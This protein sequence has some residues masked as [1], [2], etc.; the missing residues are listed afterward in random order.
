M[1]KDRLLKCTFSGIL[2]LTLVA[3]GAQTS[4]QGDASSASASSQKEELEQVD[5]SA[6][7]VSTENQQPS[8]TETTETTRTD[9]AAEPQQNTEEATDDGEP[10]PMEYPKS[11]E[12]SGDACMG[13]VV[14][15][16]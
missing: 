16:Y 14:L 3:C 13:D 10:A 7:E 5:T 4:A 15:R 8:N 6:Q 11:Q 1:S 2:A 9:T 12:Q